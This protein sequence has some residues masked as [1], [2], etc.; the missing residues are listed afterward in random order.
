MRL[1]HG[2][3]EAEPATR[4]GKSSGL[5]AVAAMRRH[6]SERLVEIAASKI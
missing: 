5:D 2:A 1:P 4:Q 3:G 6:F